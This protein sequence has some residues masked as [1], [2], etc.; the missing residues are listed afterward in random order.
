MEWGGCSLTL[1]QRT[2]TDSTPLYRGRILGIVGSFGWG[3]GSSFGMAPFSS[4]DAGYHH[5][6]LGS[7][8]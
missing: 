6:T 4:S 5:P 2:G 3:E 7:Y 8:I 1:D